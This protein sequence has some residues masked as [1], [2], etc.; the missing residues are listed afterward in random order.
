ME[1]SSP[2]NSQSQ[3]PDTTGKKQNIT[4]TAPVV[5]C[6]RFVK[7]TGRNCSLPLPKNVTG[8][9]FCT[10]HGGLEDLNQRLA[11]K[12]Q[13]QQKTSST[14]NI[15]Q[16]DK[17]E[18]SDDGSNY[19]VDVWDPLRSDFVSKNSLEIQRKLTKIFQRG[20]AI[21]DSE[22]FIYIFI[23]EG[24]V[25][26]ENPKRQLLKIGRTINDPS[27]RLKE[28]QNISTHILTLVYHTKTIKQKLAEHL[29][30]KLLDFVRVKRANDVKRHHT[31]IEWFDLELV[32]AIRVVNTVVQYLEKMYT[33]SSSSKTEI[34]EQ[35]INK[36]SLVGT[37]HS[38]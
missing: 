11:E 15:V 23:K 28:W 32:S 16:T 4:S 7:S 21:N 10:K 14:T 1:T 36:G 3:S 8:A 24:V 31:E 5:G 26:K 12:Q 19:I 33:L 30:H 18:Q 27:K 34:F 2:I 35:Q 22:G 20:P 6:H 17:S 29:I 38:K 37:K 13:Q 9:R 25:S